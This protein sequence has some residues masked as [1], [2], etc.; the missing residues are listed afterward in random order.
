MV[1]SLTLPEVMTMPTDG[2]WMGRAHVLG[3]RRIP[4]TSHPRAPSVRDGSVDL[5]PQV[6][7][8][9]GGGQVRATVDPQ[10]AL[11]PA[12]RW[13]AGGMSMAVVTTTDARAVSRFGH[14]GAG[15]TRR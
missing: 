14:P 4:M 13:S 6:A 9:P 3:L 10:G 1:S 11:S 8:W 7:V 15:G 12:T 2:L 5:G